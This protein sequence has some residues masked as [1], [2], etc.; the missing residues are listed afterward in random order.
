MSG[1]RFSKEDK[2][3]IVMACENEML[4]LKEVAAKYKV[5]I[6]TLI[7]WRYKFDLYGLKGL[8]KSIGP[9][10]YSKDL[11][12]AAVKDYLS[13]EYSLRDITNK[14][15]ISSHSV[16]LKWIDNYNCHR[17]S[18]ATIKGSQ[19]MTKGRITTWKER[20]Q[21]VLY[22]IENNKDYQKAAETYEVSYQQ[23][24]QWVRKYE[25]GKDEALIDKRGRKVAK[26]DL[27]P[28]EKIKFEMRRLERENE[29]LLAENLFLKKL[30]EIERRRK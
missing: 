10:G 20:I 5:N 2:Y 13:G 24:Y 7:E 21:V 14:Y 12:F 11:K 1:K 17:E 26:V 19:S 27:T 22:C 3:K 4:S 9:R 23:V 30:E 16:L 8:E 6:G 28:E 15:K 25:N 29:R 18:K